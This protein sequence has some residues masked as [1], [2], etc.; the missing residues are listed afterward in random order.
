MGLA[1]MMM[2]NC[3]YKYKN[4]FYGLNIVLSNIILNLEK[5][6]RW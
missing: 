5:K 2:E 4:E 6:K 1:F 3:V